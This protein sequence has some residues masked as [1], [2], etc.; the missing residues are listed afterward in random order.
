MTGRPSYKHGRCNHCGRLYSL[1][2][3][4]VLRVHF[5]KPPPHRKTCPGS[6]RQPAPKKPV[7]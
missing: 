6:R 3:T 2:T 4:G 1:T 5:L 7:R